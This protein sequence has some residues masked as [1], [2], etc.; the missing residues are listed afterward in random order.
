[1]QSAIQAAGHPGAQ[2]G[3]GLFIKPSSGQEIE[4]YQQLIL[5]ES[6]LLEAVPQFMGT[7][8]AENQQPL[9]VMED[10]CAGFTSPSVLDIKLGSCLWDESADPDKVKRLQVVSQSTTSGSLAFRIA[11][12]SV[13]LPNGTRKAFGK[14]FGRECTAETVAAHL[15]QFWPSLQD[16]N[17]CQMDVVELLCMRITEILDLLQHSFIESHSMSLLVV[18][19]GD[20][21]ELQRKLDGLGEDP[22]PQV[23]PMGSSSEDEDDDERSECV[24]RA[25]LIDFAHTKQASSVDKDACRGLSELRRCLQTLG[26]RAT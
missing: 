25:C 20:T 16:P 23:A 10:L 5:A 3:E 7:L 8:T 13:V 9:A 4:F 18:Y 15:A 11:G 6:P 2:Q 21:R 24:Y 12:M 22:P 1:M 19:E 26:H 17:S 14:Q